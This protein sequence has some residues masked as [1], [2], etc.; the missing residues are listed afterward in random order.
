[1]GS[2]LSQYT[3][4]KR[5]LLIFRSSRCRNRV[6]AVRASYSRF[7]RLG[8]CAYIASHVVVDFVAYM[9]KMF[10]EG[11]PRSATETRERV[12]GSVVIRPT[13]KYM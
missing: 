5:E 8:C 4:Q 1:M 10:G 6:R 7:C 12:T 13:R 2:C 11:T 3:L 9:L